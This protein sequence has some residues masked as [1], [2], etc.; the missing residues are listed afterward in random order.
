MEEENHHQTSDTGRRREQTLPLHATEQKETVLREVPESAPWL[1]ERKKER[2]GRG[3]IANKQQ[4]C[5]EDLRRFADG[6]T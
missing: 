6:L 2:T 4:T 3:Q 1:Q 5:G